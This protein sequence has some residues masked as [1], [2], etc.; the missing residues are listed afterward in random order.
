LYIFAVTDIRVIPRK[1]SLCCDVDF[2]GIGIMILVF[3][4]QGSGWPLRTLLQTSSRQFYTS[5][6]AKRIVSA[7]IDV[8]MPGDLPNLHCVIAL[9]NSGSV[10]SST[11]MS[12][13]VLTVSIGGPP[14]VVVMSV[15][16][17]SKVL[18]QFI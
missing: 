15:R 3:H 18:C 8:S 17:F 7:L 1:S 14:E 6:P 13:S 9:V 16:K 2:V 10:K 11:E 4:C 5:E 12:K